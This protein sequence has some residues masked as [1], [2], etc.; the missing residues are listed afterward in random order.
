MHRGLGEIGVTKEILVHRAPR[1]ILVRKGHLVVVVLG[2][3]VLKASK[4]IPGPKGHK[5]D[6]TVGGRDKG[7][8]GAQG[9]ERE[10]GDTGPQGP[11]GSGDSADYQELACAHFK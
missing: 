4:E 3:R 7:E 2:L 11:S 9:A 6:I 10:K 1:V 8:P 5:D